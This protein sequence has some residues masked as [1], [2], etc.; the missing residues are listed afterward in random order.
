MKRRDFLVQSSAA[1]LALTSG[2]AK[3][4]SMTNAEKYSMNTPIK[5]FLCGDVMTGSI[6]W[7]RK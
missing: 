4:M 7:G 5:L 1:L 6:H 2:I 3:A